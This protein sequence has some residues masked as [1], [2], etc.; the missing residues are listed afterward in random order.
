MTIEAGVTAAHP[1][2]V[3]TFRSCGGTAAEGGLCLSHRE[4]CISLVAANELGFIQL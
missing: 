1:A 3:T 2:A 4:R